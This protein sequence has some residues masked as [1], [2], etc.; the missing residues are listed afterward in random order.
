MGAETYLSPCVA[1]TTTLATA[2]TGE[3]VALCIDRSESPALEAADEGA[4]H[5]DGRLA[6]VV[7]DKEG[8]VARVEQH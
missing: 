8:V 3:H 4:H 5:S 1:H 2:R 6:C 7:V